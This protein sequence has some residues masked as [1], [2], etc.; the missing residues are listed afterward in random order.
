MTVRPEG[1]VIA[2]VYV[3]FG[4]PVKEYA[5]EELLFTL[6]EVVPVRRTCV[7]VLYVGSPESRWP[8]PSLSTKST[9]EIVLVVDA[10]GQVKP[11]PF[12]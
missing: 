12:A 3:P 1:G 8:S 2:S 10:A 11:G 5:P 9:P 7:A 6:P 4:R